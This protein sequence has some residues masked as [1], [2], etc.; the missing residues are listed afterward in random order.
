MRFWLRWAI[1]T[2]PLIGC[3]GLWVR[4]YWI[5]DIWDRYGRATDVWIA[6]HRGSVGAWFSK[7][8]PRGFSRTL[9]SYQKIAAGGMRDHLTNRQIFGFGFESLLEPPRTIAVEVPLWFLTSL[10]AIPVLWLYRRHRK[11][12]RIGF[13][14]EP[15][16]ANSKE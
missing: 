8:Q 11:R 5:E 14:I 7:H 12:R 6:L 16:A 4:S 10:S 3:L 15:V 13:P 9:W 2:L 1:V